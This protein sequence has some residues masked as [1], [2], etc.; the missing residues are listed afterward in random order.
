MRWLS[1]TLRTSEEALVAAVE[2]D[3]RGGWGERGLV[4]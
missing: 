3:V 2:V 1:N 4:R